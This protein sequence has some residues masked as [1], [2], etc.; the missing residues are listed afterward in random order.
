MT[1][2]ITTDT[3]AASRDRSRLRAAPTIL[4][5][6]SWQ[7]GHIP[8]QDCWVGV[9]QGVQHYLL[10]PHCP[11]KMSQVH[12]MSVEISRLPTFPSALGGFTICHFVRLVDGQRLFITAHSVS[13]CF[14][15]AIH[16]APS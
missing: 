6:V 15:C 9:W 7:P 8:G 10:L 13:I 12:T 1:R 5:W 3:C 11:L 2:S 14:P 16:E 4:V